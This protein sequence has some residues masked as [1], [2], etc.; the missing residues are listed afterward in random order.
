MMKCNIALPPFH[1]VE[2][3][4]FTV[5]ADHQLTESLRRYQ[6]FYRDS[7]GATV[8]ESDLLGEMARRFMA[9]DKDFQGSGRKKRQ[10]RRKGSSTIGAKPSTDGELTFDDPTK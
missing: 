4:R 9:E 10:S 6:A 5:E 2:T 3:T 8:T 1:I 7:Y